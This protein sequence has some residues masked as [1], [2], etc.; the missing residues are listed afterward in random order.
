MIFRRKPRNRRQRRPE[1]R[2]VLEVRLR[3]DRLKSSRRWIA[4]LAVTAVVGVVGVAVGTRFWDRIQD[5][6]IERNPFFAIKTI[7]VL[8]N[9]RWIRPQQVRAWAGV[10]E[11][12]NLLRLDLQRIKHD[13][14]IIPQLEGITI[15]RVPPH[16]LRISV[17]ERDPVAQVRTVQLN[18]SG[19][20][21][22]ITYFLDPTGM[23][24]PLLPEGT[25][26]PDGLAALKALPLIEGVGGRDLRPGRP[27]GTREVA[28]ALAL[29]QEFERSE[30]KRVATLASVDV[31]DPSVLVAR[32]DQGTVV[33]M[34]PLDVAQQL[35]RWWAV[36]QAGLRSSNVI[37]TLDLSVTNYCP[38]V[39]TNP[40]SQPPLSPKP[41][42]PTPSRQ[43]NV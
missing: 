40:T 3:S 32:T 20:V 17:A 18:A 14:E 41:A 26:P 39:W 5:E 7:E 4:I 42:K 35:R 25:V 1:R 9:G 22:P 13:L 2:E 31:S 10:R 23:V 16:L 19:T 8:T 36:H 24:M 34:H 15:E 12:E 38:V 37:A 29:V 27:V 28:A 30:V 21:V 43:R 11:G 6:F 33:T